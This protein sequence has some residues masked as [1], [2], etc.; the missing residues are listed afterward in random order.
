MPLRSGKTLVEMVRHRN[1]LH[2]QNNALENE[3]HVFLT[4]G[5]AHNTNPIWAN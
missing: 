3:Q 5:M 1:N 4:V 2:P